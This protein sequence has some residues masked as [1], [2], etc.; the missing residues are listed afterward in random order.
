MIPY[1]YQQEALDALHGY[2]CEKT[3]N[4]CVVIP[5]GGGK[6]ALI[7]WSIQKWKESCPWFRCIIL[8]HRKELI[9]QNANELRS[10]LHGGD[11]GIYSAALDRRDYD[12]SILFAS[13]D[14]VYNRAGDFPPWD[15][16]MVDE[17]HRIPPSG[18]GKYRTFINESRRFNPG[19]RVIGW[20]ATPFRM[21]C[22]EICYKDH[23]LNEVCYEANVANL[24][25]DGYL[26]KLRSKVGIT[27]PDLSEVKRNSGGDYITNSLSKATNADV[28]VGSAVAEAVRI[29]KAENR[30]AIVFF[31]VDVAHCVKVSNELRRHGIVAP[32]ITAKTTQL[33]RDRIVREFKDGRL[34]AI[35]NVNVF[36]EGFNARHVDCIV[37]LRPTLSAGLYSQMVGRGLRVHP[38]KRDCLVLDFAQCIETHG[39]IDLLNGGPCVLATCCNCR[40]SFS[41]AV[42]AC[43]IC[44][45]IIPK[46]EIERLDRIERERRM[47]GVK[48]SDRSI[49]ASEP[50]T[51]RVDSIQV[52]RHC[53][54]GSPDSLRVQY[55]CGLTTFRE[56]VC[57]DHDGSAGEIGQAWWR[58]RW[59]LKRGD[60]MSVDSALAS[61]LLS[62]ELL[63]WTSS[64]TVRRAGKYMEVV[65]YNQEVANV[66]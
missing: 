9:E 38:S 33:E 19:L 48:A 18:E 32:P 2:V 55:R 21:G 11:I 51:F 45:W 49:L 17:A 22:G 47:H 23:I 28:L 53:K 20:T 60:R 7:G 6:S 5:T 14:S 66:G 25:R 8:A 44:G 46:Q 24:I 39:P 15:V 29:I 42:G 26:C 40:E 13:I 30:K 16:I 64:I 62:Q 37:L 58:K 50:E 3:T 36:S 65:G 10:F 4:P 57:L 59:P 12:S 35:C 34:R 56:W 43:P 27:Q 54:D 31:A 61:L 41:R 63:D 52:S 1:P